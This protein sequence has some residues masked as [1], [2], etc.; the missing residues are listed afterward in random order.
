MEKIEVDFDYKNISISDKELEDVGELLATAVSN[1]NKRRNDNL[2]PSR[3]LPY[4]QLT[5]E[6]VSALANGLLKEIPNLV[7]V[8]FGREIDACFVMDTLR[9]VFCESCQSNDKRITIIDSFE[10]FESYL[11]DNQDEIETAAFVF[12]AG[13]KANSQLEEAIVSLQDLLGKNFPTQNVQDHIV[14]I[15]S[16][17]DSLRSRF[18]EDSGCKSLTLPNNLD[19]KLNLLSSSALLPLSFCGYDIE[20]LLAGARAMDERVSSEKL[21]KNPAAIIAAL[22]RHYSALVGTEI[23]LNAQTIDSDC[24]G[25]WYCN[26]LNE[27]MQDANLSGVINLNTT[28]QCAESKQRF[29]FEIS[30][31][32]AP[33]QSSDNSAILVI[34]ELTPYTLG[35]L[36]YFCEV[37]I[38]I[39]KELLNAKD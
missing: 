38:S 34:E 24:F 11:R 1:I 10:K 33:E 9:K 20:Q 29:T 22:L 23:C 19:S 13:E 3:D 21:E 39:L 4:N 5:L 31:S 6:S 30:N 18:V 36:I 2:S 25:Q 35:E 28:N 27:V 15:S 16:F 26:L 14:I 32:P 37:S 8:G 17:A 7:V 12:V